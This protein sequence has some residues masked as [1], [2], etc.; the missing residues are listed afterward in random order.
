[1]PSFTSGF[2][3]AKAKRDPQS[4]EEQ[5]WERQQKEMLLARAKHAADEEH[6]DVKKMNQLALYAKC[7][8]VRDKQ[9]EEKVCYTQRVFV[10]SFLF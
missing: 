9:L 8:A 4:L 6:E 7:V 3:Q 1:M 5:A 2:T 10:E